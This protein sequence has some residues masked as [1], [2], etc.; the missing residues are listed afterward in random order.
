MNLDPHVRKAELRL[1][2]VESALA[3]F[4][5]TAADA[6]RKAY[7]RLN[8]E[9]RRLSEL[10]TAAAL[11]T[12]AT[13]DLADNEALLATETDAEFLSAVH[14]DIEALAAQLPEL[15][16]RVKLLLLPPDPRESRNLI[17]EIRPAAGGD[18]AG[19]FAADLFRMYS[20][21]IE[22]KGWRLELL[23]LSEN[24]VGGI[25]N[26]AF[27]VQGE[28]AYGWMR[29]ESG[30]HR[31]QRVPVTEAA[32]RIHT[33]TVTV[34]VL[35]EAEE[36]DVDIRP[37]DLRI[38][39]F[40]SSGPGGQSVNTTDS[41]VRVTHIP[42]GVSVASQQE[43][44]QHRNRE[45][46]LRLLRARLFEAKRQ[47]EVARNAAQRRQQVGTGERSERIRTYNFPQNRLT[48]HRFGLTRYDLTRLMEGEI[49]E[50]LEDIIAADVEDR[51]AAELEEPAAAPAPAK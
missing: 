51:L 35:P 43:K 34:A 28:G 36:V 13:R 42:S 44:S 8:R 12:K 48:D 32:G 22:R 7:E 2:E 37:E 5:F 46:A 39:V 14:A 45:I 20:R 15:E 3:A 29:F 33:S 16:R 26:L 25:K 10:C 21:L 38:D 9:Y 40:R 18:E 23:D 50:L 31:V 30:V 19:L 27:S 4:D 41:A 49:G 17:V 47:E 6:D 11:L 1:R 24:A